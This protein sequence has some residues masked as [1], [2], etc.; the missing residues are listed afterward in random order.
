MPHLDTTRQRRK[1]SNRVRKALFMAL[2]GM[3]RNPGVYRNQIRNVVKA[4][5]TAVEVEVSDTFDSGFD[6]GDQRNPPAM[7]VAE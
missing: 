6:C 2:D 4:L 7:R 3:A 1:N 5:F